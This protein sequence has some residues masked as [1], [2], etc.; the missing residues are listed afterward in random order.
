MLHSSWFH[1]IAAESTFP[2]RNQRD[3]SW[4]WQFAA[5]RTR[6]ADA[7][8]SE[9]WLVD[10]CY[11]TFFICYVCCPQNPTHSPTSLFSRLFS[12]YLD[13]L[14]A[15][16]LSLWFVLKGT[17]SWTCLLQT[18]SYEPARSRHLNK[19]VQSLVYHQVRSVSKDIRKYLQLQINFHA[20]PMDFPC[21]IF[22]MYSGRE[23]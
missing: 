9:G 19:K 3:P 5:D 21:N 15:D 23:S 20:S 17:G 2:C 18:W 12:E 7:P 8:L 1:H 22:M 10:W 14:G 11:N 4:S 6:A 13:G 16:G